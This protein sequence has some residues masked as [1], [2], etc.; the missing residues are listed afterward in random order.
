VVPAVHSV[1]SHLETEVASMHPNQHSLNEEQY[2]KTLSNHGV[3]IFP[4][5][6]APTFLQ[7]PDLSLLDFLSFVLVNR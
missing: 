4:D 2:L 3:L 1:L 6:S 5:S 7:V